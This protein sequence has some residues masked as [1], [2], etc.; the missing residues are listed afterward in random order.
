MADRDTYR[1][2]STPALLKTA[3]EGI[4]AE[5]AVVLAERLER[6]HAGTGSHYGTTHN[7]MGGRYQFNHRSNA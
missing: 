1:V 4:D 7:S 6:L 5:L 2:L 3:R